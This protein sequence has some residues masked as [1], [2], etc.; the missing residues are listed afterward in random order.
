MLKRILL[1]GLALVLIG[2]ILIVEF[3]NAEWNRALSE[4]VWVLS[5][6]VFIVM[7]ALVVMTTA[8][9]IT[10]ILGPS[11]KLPTTLE[12]CAAEP[13]PKT[14]WRRRLLLGLGAVIAIAASVAALLAFIEHEIKSSDVYRMSLTKGQQ[15]AD[16]ARIVGLPVKPGWFVTGEIAESTNGGG[17]A[18]LSIPLDG[19][20]GG[21]I[22]HVQAQRRGGSWRIYV[23][24]FE[25]KDKNSAVDLLGQPSN[26]HPAFP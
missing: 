16:I 3:P 26:E 19:P 10:K 25:S 18:T 11:K 15:S 4:I 14:R 22:L 6:A 1:F 5:I 9:L 24:E 7:L 23:L 8:R 12:R 17:R 20:R 13:A 2:G 21:G